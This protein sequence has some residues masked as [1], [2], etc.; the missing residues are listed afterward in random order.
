MFYKLVQFCNIW[1]LLSMSKKNCLNITQL[2][3]SSRIFRNASEILKFLLPFMAVSLT[4]RQHP[5]SAAYL[6]HREILPSPLHKDIKGG[7]R[8]IEPLILNSA[9]DEGQFSA[10]GPA[11]YTPGNTLNSLNSKLC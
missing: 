10:S 11:R 8:G 2:Q 1:K 6:R 7:S 3:A 5:F 9:L 4:K